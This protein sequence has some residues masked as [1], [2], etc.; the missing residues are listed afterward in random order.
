MASSNSGLLPS[1]PPQGKTV[2]S[3]VERAECIRHCRWVDEVLTD[4]PWVITSDFI[5]RHQIDYVAHD[6]LPYADATGQ[7]DDVYEP[8]RRMGR[9]L[10]RTAPAQTHRRTRCPAPPA[11]VPCPSCLG[12]LPLLT[13]CPAPPD[14]VPSTARVCTA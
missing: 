5:E 7:F 6:A 1:L 13:R 4:A 8:V 2:M 11:S 9:F 14:S 3:Q 12:A 10:V